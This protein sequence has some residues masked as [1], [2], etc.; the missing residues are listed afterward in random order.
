MVTHS[1]DNPALRIFWKNRY[2][3]PA[4]IASALLLILSMAPERMDQSRQLLWATFGIILIIAAV[5]DAVRPSFGT[6]VTKDGLPA[7]V[8]LH[9]GLSGCWLGGSILIDPHIARTNEYAYLVAVL[10][11]GTMIGLLQF[12]TLGRQPRRTSNCSSFE[13]R[14]STARSRRPGTPTTTR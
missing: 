12:G 8:H 1:A 10:V 14:G 11:L 5:L 4:G 7:T 3:P 13:P 2:A 6:K 9:A